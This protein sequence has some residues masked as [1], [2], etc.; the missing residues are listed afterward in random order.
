MNAPSQHPTAA[1]R[2]RFGPR[3]LILP[4]LL[5]LGICAFRS[6]AQDGNYFLDFTYASGANAGSAGW[7]F[8]HVDID[9]TDAS[10][11]TLTEFEMHFRDSGGRSLG[12]FG[13]ADVTQFD[14][15]AMFDGVFNTVGF[16]QFQGDRFSLTG[17]IDAPD[18]NLTLP[19]T[20]VIDFPNGRTTY[21]IDVRYSPAVPEPA[22]ALGFAGVSL[23]LWAAATRRNRGRPGSRN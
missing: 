14:G 15:S 18:P 16:G 9:W 6:Q 22:A 13:L 23:V 2:T 21:T 10:K 17:G 7:G 3:L 20:A 8:H 4:A 12:Q 1:S 19:Y 5:L 11:P